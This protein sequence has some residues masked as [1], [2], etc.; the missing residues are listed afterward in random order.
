M[1]L[2]PDENSTTVKFTVT[3]LVVFC[4]RVAVTV[5]LFVSVIR[6]AARPYV[7]CV[8]MSV[9]M[10]PQTSI[11]FEVVTDE[12]VAVLLLLPEAIVIVPCW[13]L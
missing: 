1:E 10:P 11:V 5:V 7:V 3:L 6:T 4:S 8:E 9:L 13:M 12:I 2:T